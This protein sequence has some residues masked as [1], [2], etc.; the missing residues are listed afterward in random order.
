MT[1]IIVIASILLA[2]LG[3]VLAIWSIIDTRKKHY[4]DYIRRKR[5]D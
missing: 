3:I 2:L 5:N 1:T 4:N